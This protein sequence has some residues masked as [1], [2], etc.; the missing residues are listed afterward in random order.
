MLYNSIQVRCDISF[1]FS[2]LPG[3]RFR[4]LSAGVHCTLRVALGVYTA[5]PVGN[6][7]ERMWIN[8]LNYYGVKR[9]Q[10]KLKH[11]VKKQPKKKCFSG[12]FFEKQTRQTGF[13]L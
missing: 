8:V 7:C 3:A 2:I 12:N 9:V 10:Q 6:A 5:P 1:F 13:Y 11:F 4:A